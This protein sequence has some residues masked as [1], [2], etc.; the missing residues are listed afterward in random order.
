MAAAGWEMGM[1][2]LKQQ[3]SCCPCSVQQGLWRALEHTQQECMEIMCGEKGKH[4]R[5][6]AVTRKR[7]CRNLLLYGV[8]CFNWSQLTHV[9]KSGIQGMCQWK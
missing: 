3:K 6:T 5:G 1:I 7:G 2:A 8:T 4:L 9:L